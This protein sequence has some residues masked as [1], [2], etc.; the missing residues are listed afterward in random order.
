MACLPWF[1]II[2]RKGYW[3]QPSGVKTK[4]FL[5]MKQYEHANRWADEL[6]ARPEVQRGMLVCRRY[7]KPWLEGERF[8]HLKGKG[9]EQTPSKWAAARL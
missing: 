6:C 4:E 9:S 5:N 8:A 1:D 3:H 7:P 2:R